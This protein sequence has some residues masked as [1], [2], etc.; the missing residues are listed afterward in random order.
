MISNGPFYLERY[1]PDS[2]SIIVKS[3]DSAEYPLRQGIWNE[4]EQT[5]FPIIKS[6]NL[7]EVVEKGAK[8]D[9]SVQTKYSTEIHYFL[10]NA[11]GEIITSGIQPIYDDFTIITFEKEIMQDIPLG[12]STLK[13]FAASDNVL[14]PYEFSTSFLIVESDL[15]LPEFTISDALQDE[16]DDDYSIFIIIIILAIIGIILLVK[17][18]RKHKL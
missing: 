1:S 8:L 18:Q 10:S 6:V 14:K 2:R 12:P 13:I 3:F 17:N 15:F 9:I 5:E 7:S 11:R 16:Q 4:F